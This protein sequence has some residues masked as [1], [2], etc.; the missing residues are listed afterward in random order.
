MKAHSV[1]VNIGRGGLVD[2]GALL[3]ALDKGKPEHAILDVF[4]SEPL[5]EDSPFWTHPRVTLT[6]HASAIGSGL[7]RRT[8]D[9]F[10]ENL[11]RYLRGETLLNEADPV[12]VR[13]G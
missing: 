2:E 12:D 10:V 8:D 5:N 11:G 4:R 13:A 9:L 3:A 1:L 7:V 6:P